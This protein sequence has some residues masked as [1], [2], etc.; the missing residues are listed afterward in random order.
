MWSNLKPLRRYTLSFQD[1]A[2][3]EL[4]KQFRVDL[5]RLIMVDHDYGSEGV[6]VRS[7]GGT[8]PPASKLFSLSVDPTSIRPTPIHGR[9]TDQSINALLSGDSET[10][11]S[12]TSYRNAW[13]QL[14]SI[15]VRHSPRNWW[16]GLASRGI[17]VSPSFSFYGPTSSSQKHGSFYL[18][19]N[20]N[21]RDFLKPR[22][23]E[24]PEKLSRTYRAVSIAVA[25]SACKP[26]RLG[27]RHD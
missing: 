8:L 7:T 19:P 4:E 26:H 24:V 13:R 23:L 15:S 18:G 12:G 2:C 25:M 1:E 11:R 10:S 5:R 6:M 16:C 22:R 21:A 27:L 20:E 17:Q 9:Q 14:K 3:K